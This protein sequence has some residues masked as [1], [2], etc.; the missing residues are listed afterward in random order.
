[1]PKPGAFDLLSTFVHLDRGAAAASV[2]LTRSF[3]RDL[4][5]GKRSF[6]GRLMGVVRLASHSDHWEAHPAGDEL[7]FRLSGEMDVLL[8]R[9]GR[10]RRVRLSARAP[11]CLVPRGVWHTLEVRR[12][13]ALLFV[14]P[15]AGTRRRPA[16]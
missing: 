1:M 7:L 2:P 9:R 12:P 10:R 13:G 15:G 8:E 11:C 4:R 6:R 5:A 14:T 3:W 16:T